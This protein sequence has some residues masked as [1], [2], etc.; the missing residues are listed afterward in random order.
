MS[1]PKKIHYCWFGHG[2]MPELA[3]SCINS[4]KRFLPDYELILWNEDNTDINV[5]Q[6]VSEAYKAKK[7]AFVTDYVRLY[8]LYYHGGIYMDTDVEVLKSFDR[9]LEHQAFTGCESENMCGTGVIGSEKKHPWI[10]EL[11]NYYDNSKF[12]LPFGRINTT[13]NPQIITKITVEK[14]GWVQQNKYQVLECG[15]HIYPSDV[16]C[17]KDWLTGKLTVTDNTHAIHHFLGSWINEKDRKRLR[18]I[19]K[20]VGNKG[21]NLLLKIKKNIL[22]R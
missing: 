8:A 21:L 13:P 22:N 18:L 20:V 12:V 9:F 14:Y 10:K 6:Y 17:A 15:L 1:I 5:N 19:T 16:F 11:L 4:W 7:F 2:K 3:I